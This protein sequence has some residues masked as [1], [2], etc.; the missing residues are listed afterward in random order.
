MSSINPKPIKIK[1][2]TMLNRLS[3]VNTETLS[4]EELTRY[5]NLTN[6][7][8]IKLQ[9]INIIDSVESEIRKNMVATKKIEAANDTANEIVKLI[10]SS[11]PNTNQKITKGVRYIEHVLADSAVLELNQDLSNLSQVVSD[12]NQYLSTL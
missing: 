2:E 8:Q 4:P 7:L 5:E 1:I 6:D 3:R 10:S 12:A 11:D 9:D